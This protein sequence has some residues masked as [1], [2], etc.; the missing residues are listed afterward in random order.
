MNEEIMNEEVIE[1]ATDIIEEVANT[2]NTQIIKYLGAG[3][4]IIV[5]AGVTVKVVRKYGVPKW[6]EW[7]EKRAAKK[8]ERKANNVIVIDLEENENET[9]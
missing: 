3:A 2:D 5:V 4:A 6:N 7:Q 9:E 8:E 1:T